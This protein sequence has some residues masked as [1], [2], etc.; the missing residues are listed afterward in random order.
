MDNI[1]VYLGIGLVVGVVS[2]SVGIGGGVLMLPALMWLCGMEPRCAA[3]TTLAVLVVPVVLPAAYDYWCNHH[4]NV[5][6]A[7]WIALAFAIGGYTGAALRTNHVLPDW[8]LRL[9]L[10]L[11]MMYI[12]LNL[13]VISD[14]E[15]AKAAA[16]VTAT[17]LAWLTFLWLRAVGKGALARPKLHEQIQRMHEQGHGDPDYYI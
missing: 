1:L 2:G 14:S 11:I 10:G 16:G 4:V 15:A 13:I 8:L 9:G 17:L 5:K 3:G 7:L 6:A 12:A